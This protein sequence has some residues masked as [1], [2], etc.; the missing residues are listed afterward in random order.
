[1]VTDGAGFVTLPLGEAFAL[2]Q[3]GRLFADEGDEEAAG[4]AGEDR[5]TLGVWSTLLLVR[6]GLI[7]CPHGPLPHMPACVKP[8][9]GDL[10]RAIDLLFA[11]RWTI[12][13]H[14]PIPL[15]RNFVAAWAGITPDVARRGVEWML[16]EGVVEH[17]A[18]LAPKRSGMEG[19]RLYMPHGVK[20]PKAWSDQHREAIRRADEQKQQY[21]ETERERR[22]RNLAAKMNDTSQ[23]R[24][25]VRRA[26]PGR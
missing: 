15:S 22:I 1:Y 16:K 19:L 26:D 12:F 23:H 21:E 20:P 9:R 7:S 5:P 13:D 2:R 10:W 17:V 24:G 11:C 3:S 4:S 18:T 25:R 8:G 14:C 6:A